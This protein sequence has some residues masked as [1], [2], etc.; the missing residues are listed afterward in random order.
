MTAASAVAIDTGWL[1][2]ELIDG[3]YLD[4]GNEVIAV[5]NEEMAFVGST[6]DMSRVRITYQNANGA[7]PQSMIAK[8]RGRDEL[9]AQMDAALHLFARE[10]YFYRDVAKQLPVRTPEVFAIGDGD[11]SPLM[12]EDLGSLRMGDQSTGLS[13]E[14]ATRCVD[15]LADMHAILWNS[16]DFDS[17]LMRPQDAVTIATTSQ[18]MLSGVA[19]ARSMLAEEFESEVLTLLPDDSESWATLLTKLGDGPLTVI[20]NDCRADNLFFAADGA[21]VFV[22]WQ[23]VAAARASQDLANLLVG[24][25]GAGDLSAC[26]RELLTRYH[27]R[28]VAAGV[29]DYRFEDLV[30]H[31]RQS[32]L[33]PLGQGLALIGALSASDTRLV[34]PQ[35]VRRVLGHAIEV[36]TFAA[37]RD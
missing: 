29:A 3:G 21:P 14:D 8:I 36:D 7:G 9:R 37:F 32:I 24:S 27:G 12:L 25:M 13:V 33:W 16:A 11:A 4:F 17:R 6:S 22:D 26:W 31:Y 28:L 5:T 10:A 20:H 2:K 35:I 1:T 19:A 30:V 18:L 23:M 34:G 15:A